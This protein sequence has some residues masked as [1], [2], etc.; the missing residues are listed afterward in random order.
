MLAVG[1]A[2]IVV[3]EVVLV[4]DVGGVGRADGEHCSGAFCPLSSPDRL[5]LGGHDS[6][7]R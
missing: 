3:G 5:E 1:D 7:S 6:V 2:E 4:D